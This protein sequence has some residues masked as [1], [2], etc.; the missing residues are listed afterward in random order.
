[1]FDWLFEGRASV[2]IFLAALAGVMLYVWWRRRKR[3]YL[4]AAVGAV[5]LAGVYFLLDRAVETDREQ[6]ERKL[7]EMAGAVRERAPERIFAH[8]SESFRLGTVNRAGFREYVGMVDRNRWVDELKVW[9]FEFAP[10]FKE[11]GRVAFKAKPTG[12]MTGGAPF[13]R[14]EAVFHRD[15]D[16]EWR[17]QTF[18]LF[19]PLVDSNQPLQIPH[20]SQ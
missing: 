15:P 7:T 20:L 10:D 17:L 6:I 14:V 5:A 2:Y 12:T 4:Y 1:V 18:Q 16:G 8:I 13:Y 11:T 19:N 3:S 9:D